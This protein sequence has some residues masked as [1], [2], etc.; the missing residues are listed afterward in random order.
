MPLAVSFESAALF[1]PM[2][3]TIR[4]A[5]VQDGEVWLSLRSGQSV[6]LQTYDTPLDMAQKDQPV[7]EATPIAIDTPWTL[8]FTDDSTPAPTTTFAMDK[9]QTWEMLSSETA[10][11]MGTGV[12]ET[13]L[14]LTQRQLLMG[15]AGFRLY[16]GDVRE[17]ARVYIN[18]V[19][20]GCAWSA[21]FVLDVSGMLHEGDNQLRIEVTNLPANR[22]SQMDR[23]G[24]VWRKFKDVNILD[25]VNGSNSVSGV[26]YNEWAPVPSGLA[27]QPRL[28][29]LRSVATALS[30]VFAGFDTDGQ[31]CYP[32]Y[33]LVAPSGRPIASV[34]VTRADGQPYTDYVLTEN[35]SRIRLH[36]MAVG[37]VTLRVADS[38]GAESEAYVQA[39]GAYELLSVT[40]LTT[41]TPPDGGWMELKNDN[42]ITGFSATGKL[43]WR[44]ANKNGKEVELFSGLTFGCE[45]STYY[46]FYPGYGM[47]CNNDFTISHAAQPRDV[48][49]VSYLQ[50]TGE[51]TYNAADS[52]VTAQQCAE[53]ATAATIALPGTTAMTIYRSVQHYRPLQSEEDGIVPVAAERKATA[54]D[55]FS[56]QGQRLAVPRKGLYIRHGRK[57]VVR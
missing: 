6:I 41:S 31:H 33:R 20:A 40:D 8:S 43:P 34:S 49:L 16:L 19:Y 50:G 38:D 52:L 39:P 22:I 3:G 35:N 28:V 14:S 45:R 11:L 51:S 1:D 23:D 9:A 32:A 21:P 12:Y 27:S 17:S 10:R 42:I 29:P 13:T 48:T 54:G 4:Q 55:W 26:T 5:S 56:I 36:A 24:T 7:V 46:F 18:N 30:A 53:G 47:T 15:N 25:I 2:T 37:T 57:V 44:R